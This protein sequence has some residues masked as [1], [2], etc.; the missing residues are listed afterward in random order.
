MKNTQEWRDRLGYYL[1]G[2]KKFFN[3]SLALIEEK[4]TNESVRWIFN[5]SAYNNINW[6]IPIETSLTELY[7]QRAQQLRDDYDY[8]VLYFS[9]G[10][11]SLNILHAF[12]D[13]NIFLDELVVQYPKALEHTFNNKDSSTG[14]FYS[15]MKYAAFPLLEQFKNKLNS[16]TKIRHQDLS[17]IIFDIFK[18]D[19]WFER[20]PMGT[21]ITVNGIARQHIQVAE[22]H[23]LDLCSKGKQVAQ[24]LGVDKP[25]VVYDG[26]NYYSY[27]MDLSAMHA[28]P[29]DL[30]QK[31]VYEKFYHAEFFYWTP[32]MPEI[33]VKQAQEIK[34][35]C[36]NNPF[37]KHMISQSRKLHVSQFR[38]ILH[39]II[40]PKNLTIEF[41]T[42]KPESKLIREQDQ[43][44]WHLADEE[45][46]N[47]YWSVIK[48]LQNN[49]NPENMIMNDI[50]NGLGP[51]Y[52][53]YYKL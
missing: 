3:K 27:F 24:I 37:H 42:D 10:A 22:T 12:V 51:S 35:S 18:H 11:D 40:Y 32:D 30:N 20:N 21:N 52:S 48:Y 44:F 1:V 2:N 33:V 25:L 43:Y 17:S 31:E 45:I 46:K 38:E 15:E 47:N 26:R 23:I 49:T 39:P 53:K 16:N 36:E 6:T 5:D 28:P 13:N 29:V 50:M 9:G 4:L 14:N 19:D 34:K 8:L 41:Q 7:R